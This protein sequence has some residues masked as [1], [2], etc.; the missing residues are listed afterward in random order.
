MKSKTLSFISALLCVCLIACTLPAVSADAVL[1]ESSHPYVNG[2]RDVKTYSDQSAV[3]GLFVTFSDDT[4]VQ[5]YEN[6]W[7]VKSGHS[8]E[9]V[10]DLISHLIRSGDLI[11][12]Y[13]GDHRTVGTYSGDSLAGKTLYIP[14]SSFE[15]VLNADADINGY[16][17]R[18]T[19]VRPAGPDD[20][21]SI[22]YH[23]GFNGLSETV[24]VP[25]NTKG[26][27]REQCE[28]DGEEYL[29]DA[30]AFSGWSSE[31]GGG[32]EYDPD[33]RIPA[34]MGDCDLWAVWT[35]LS[36]KSEEVLSF[37]NSGWYFEDDGRGNYYLTEK[38]YRAMQLNLYKNFGLGPVPGP[39]I[40]AVL[41]T[42]PNWEWQGSCY[43]MSTVIALQH[44]G[45]IDLLPMQN[46]TSVS[47]L[48]A[49]DEL[50]SRINYYQSQAATSWLTENKAYNIGS[51]SY[52]AQLRRICETV[53]AGNTV[54][55]TFYPDK[56]FTEIGHTVLFTGCYTKA[57]GSHVL[58]AYD[59]N[60]AWSYL[61]GYYDDHFTV[62]ADY[63]AITDDWDDDIGAFNWT[64]RFNQFS[65]FDPSLKGS[66][67]TWYAALLRHFIEL[68]ATLKTMLTV[69]G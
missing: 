22:T 44:F 2:A 62:A 19:D 51:V 8:Y 64:D 45:Q 17:Y 31:Q 40:S 61:D 12:V 20:V 18:V 56:A 33:G 10:D 15:I 43:G 50:I 11:T 63:S 66:P 16:G 39:V 4:W 23:S 36:L 69:T 60:D 27:F 5:P 68:F 54:L 38:D 30:F 28:I 65:S 7:I 26:Y 25:R 67:I 29:R 57:D 24:F 35:P 49:D 41:A 37:S 32:V 47:E 52:R 9:N 42:Y 46:V 21:R 34:E 59:C 58:I 48:E 3:R 14:T 55:F 6:H 13:D 53:A 1:P